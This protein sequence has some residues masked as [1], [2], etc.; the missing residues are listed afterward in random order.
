MA[1]STDPWYCDICTNKTKQ[2]AKDYTLDDVMKKLNEMDSKYQVLFDKYEQQVEINKKLESEI[3][4]LKSHL[5]KR[6]QNELK[7]NIIIQ[8]VP[9]KTNENLQEIVTKIG[10][11]LEVRVHDNFKAFRIGLKG[12]TNAAIKVMFQDETTKNAFLKSKNK[13]HLNSND[14]GFKNTNV[15]IFLNQD[16]TKRNLELLRAAKV[17]KDENKYKFLWV[18]NGSVLL[19][20]DENAKVLLV[21]DEK[22]LKS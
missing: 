19:R 5:N 22:K 1:K 14:L 17:F 13:F 18:S 3:S 9:T 6:E 16:L 15:K 7:N 10:E 12:N 21:D 11:C 8:G 2:Q 20:K 4:E